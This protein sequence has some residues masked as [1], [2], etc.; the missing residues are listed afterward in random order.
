MVIFSINYRF[1]TQIENLES[2]KIKCQKHEINEKEIEKQYSFIIKEKKR[3]IEEQK[4]INFESKIDNVFNPNE[5]YRLNMKCVSKNKPSS[6]GRINYQYHPTYYKG[7]NEEYIDY[8]NGWID[9][10]LFDERNKIINQILEMIQIEIKKKKF[11]HG[12]TG[13]G[14]THILIDL[15]ARLIFKYLKENIDE[16]PEK[17]IF[18]FMFNIIDFDPYKF[19]EEFYFACYPLIRYERALL[20]SAQ[21]LNQNSL[22]DIQQLTKLESYF[23]IFFDNI[24]IDDD[25][26]L[27]IFH[28]I[29]IHIF[30]TYKIPLIVIFDQINEIKKTHDP[31]NFLFLDLE[32]QKLKI[33]YEIFIREQTTKII[34]ASNDNE[35]MRDI[36][37]NNI[38]FDYSGEE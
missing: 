14:K 5:N 13:F 3:L 38:K 30:K 2:S 17:I 21:N 1:T 22:N 18:Y 10:Y 8:T 16:K 31:E 27:K 25:E 11:F 9:I 37:I 32:P 6:I 34:C 28:E 7:E 12:N 24:I 20:R 4:Y 36:L 35:I 29:L 26:N 15:V 23:E 19:L 33:F